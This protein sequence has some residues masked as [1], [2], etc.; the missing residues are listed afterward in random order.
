MLLK[1]SENVLKSVV[2][3]VYVMIY[4]QLKKK[5]KNGFIIIICFYIWHNMTKDEQYKTAI[6]VRPTSW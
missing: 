2:L 3:K 4:I 5:I 6:V 1:D